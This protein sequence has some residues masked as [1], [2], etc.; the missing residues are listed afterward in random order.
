M[1]KKFAYLEVVLIIMVF[2]LINVISGCS[3]ND[4]HITIGFNNQTN[5]ELEIN[6]SFSFPD[7]SLSYESF[8]GGYIAEPLSRT[9]L[10]REWKKEID[11]FSKSGI[12]ILFAI[13]VDT[14]QLYGKDQ[15]ISGYK[16]AKRYELSID[17][18]N[19][20]G[21]EICFP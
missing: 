20:M 4:N 1:K 16:I 10:N 2:S 9:P 21:W 8:R 14:M 3:K 13:D 7:T 18:L 11:L 6:V 12:V 17:K 5:K 19:S 15:V